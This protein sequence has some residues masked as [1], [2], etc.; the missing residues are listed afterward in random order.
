[1]ETYKCRCCGNSIPE[2]EFVWDSV[3]KD[4]C[5]KFIEEYRHDT[6]KC[7]DISKDEE[8][9]IKIN[10]F[11]ASQFTQ[12]QIERILFFELLKKEYDSGVD[13]I[14]FIKSELEWFIEGIKED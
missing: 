1:M 4:C 13:Y 14:N 10:L 2:G 3:C 11:L 8:K 5:D 6:E 12:E 7:I 9:N